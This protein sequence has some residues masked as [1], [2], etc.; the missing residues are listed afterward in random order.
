MPG[1]SSSDTLES[2]RALV[3][4]VYVNLKL[5]LRLDL[6]RSRET[7]P[8]FFDRVRRRYPSMEA[9]KKYRDELALETNG[10]E[11]PYRWL[12]V[13]SRNI[14][15]GVV[16]PDAYASAHDLHLHV[17]EGAPYFLSISA[18]DVESVEVLFGMDLHAG[19]NHDEI[20]F[21]ALVADSPLASLVDAGSTVTDCQP[22][23]AWTSGLGAGVEAQYEVKTRLH[24]RGRSDG[25]PEPLSVYL[26][27]RRAGPVQELGDLLDVYRRLARIGEELVDE[28]VVPS[29]IR[30]IRAAIT[31]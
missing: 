19:S 22:M 20:V 25:Q 8:E 6:P 29:L 26:T 11:G 15:S 5:S 31:G 12:A 13:R 21:N 2:V 3:S 24:G 14:R 1:V 9:L 16:N 4:D 30:P 17:L 18:L 23:L 7:V 10:G 28:R 27:M